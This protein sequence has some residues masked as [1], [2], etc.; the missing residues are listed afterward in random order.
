MKTGILWGVI[1]VV[2]D[3]VT[4]LWAA[5]A[6]KAGSMTVIPDVLA[7]TYAEN[8]GM[9][10]SMFAGHPRL[11]AVVSLALVACVLAAM[12][13]VLPQTPLGY[14]LQGMLLGG[15]VGNA[16]D[17]LLYGYVI[18]FIEPLFMEFAIFNVADIAV[19][20][21]ALALVVVSCLPHTEEKQLGTQRSE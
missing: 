7:F 15:G 9:A 11:L 10:F 12:R 5:G 13:S 21:G 1:A 4:K 8:T 14:A 20:L 18:D 17:R 3:R 16:I 19:T 6:L 2:L